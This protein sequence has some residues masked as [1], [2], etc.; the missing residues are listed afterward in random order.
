[1]TAFMEPER[2]HS[3]RGLRFAARPTR[4]APR[5]Q[6]HDRPSRCNSSGG[7]VTAV[8]G[9]AFRWSR[10]IS[11]QSPQRLALGDLA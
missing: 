9:S 4:F 7:L 11:R 5:I 6:T 2:I 8:G 10:V 1:M 3:G